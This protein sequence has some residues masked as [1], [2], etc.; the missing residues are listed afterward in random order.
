MSNIYY[1]LTSERGENNFIDT[2]KRHSRQLSIIKK[3]ILYNCILATGFLLL[4][5]LISLIII[6]SHNWLLHLSSM[7]FSNLKIEHLS[8]YYIKFFGFCLSD[9]AVMILLA[10]SSMT[11]FSDIVNSILISTSAACFGM[12][13]CILRFNTKITDTYRIVYIVYVF[14]VLLIFCII[15]AYSSRFHR[16]F[17]YANKLNLNYKSIFSTNECKN[18][19]FAL[20]VSGIISIVIKV[21]YCAIINLIK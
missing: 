12:G 5:F 1:R 19:I 13:T 11:F 15:S 8:D 14:T 6:P 9:I 4:G 20:S 17:R 16:A 10:I 2:T 3:L 18:L 7:H 21:I